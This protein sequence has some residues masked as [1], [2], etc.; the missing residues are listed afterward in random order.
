MVIDSSGHSQ[1]LDSLALGPAEL[2]LVRPIMLSLTRVAKALFGAEFADAVLFGKD[3]VWRASGIEVPD[4]ANA[5]ISALARVGDAVVWIPDLLSDARFAGNPGLASRGLHGYVGA[6]VRLSDGAR[7]GALSIYSLK[8]LPF[9]ADRASLLQDLAD[10]VGY[11]CDRIRA[12][13]E[14]TALIAQVRRSE[15]R[16][17]IA[18][19]NAD[20]C[21]YE[22]DYGAQELIRIGDDSSF[23]ETPKTYEEC[24]LDPFATTLPADRPVVEAAWARHVAEGVTNTSEWRINRT[25]KVVWVNSTAEVYYDAAG[26]PTCMIGSFQNITE[27]KLAEQAMAEAKSAAEDANRAKSSFL[28][29]MSHEIRT[30]LNGVLGM[31]QAMEVDDLSP[32]QRDRLD[33]IRRSGEG[34]LAILNDMLDLSKI[35]AGKMELETVEFDLGEIARGAHATFTALAN[36][37]GLSFCLDAEA[38]GGVYRGD[39][40]RTRQVLYNL[41]SN[42]LKFTETGEVRVSVAYDGE[43]LVTTVADTGIGMSPQVLSGLFTSFTQADTSTTRRFGGTGLGLAICKQLSELMGGSILVT[44]V[45]GQG[46]AFVFRAPMERVGEAQIARS[47]EQQASQPTVALDIR[48]LA[49]EDNS[50]NQLVLKTLLLQIGVEPVIVEN[51]KLA[52]EAWEE[53]DWDVILMDVQMPVMDGPTAV[54]TI[55]ERE[56][57]TGR[58]RTPILAL[59]A[60]ALSHQIAHYLACGMDAHV[61]KPIEAIKLFNALET[62][63]A[64][65]GEE[66]AAHAAK[67]AV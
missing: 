40:T 7:V 22:I 19:A 1:M 36:K 6:A 32:I 39:P 30:P 46:S 48:V 3:C 58:T 14:H 31:A 55:R 47:V 5:P 62:A 59:T 66:V 50:V 21:I 63:L 53:G 10:V 49:A 45:E 29:T 35:E 23:F 56:T 15:Q 18:V 43:A 25:D 2:E 17:K 24:A 60:N 27:R 34:L 20:L 42:A 57:A 37:K 11:E 4:L 38:A 65:P 54:R 41:I 44:S 12:I 67:R 51:G 13:S 61:V 64:A 33:V 9:D 28:A 8:P 26:A 52:V 16:L